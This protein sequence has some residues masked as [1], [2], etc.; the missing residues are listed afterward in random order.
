ME[1]YDKLPFYVHIPCILF[2]TEAGKYCSPFKD[3]SRFEENTQQ[4][5]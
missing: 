4:G 5:E 1:I 2:H 3:E